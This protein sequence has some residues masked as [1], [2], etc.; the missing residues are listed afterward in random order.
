M[1]SD[2]RLHCEPHCWTIRIFTSIHPAVLPDVF[3]HIPVVQASRSCVPPPPKSA[4]TKDFWP[5]VLE[6][7]IVKPFVWQVA[8]ISENMFQHCWDEHWWTSTRFHRIFV[9]IHEFWG[10]PTCRKP[11]IL[12]MAQPWPFQRPPTMSVHTETATSNTRGSAPG[13]A[14]LCAP[15]CFMHTIEEIQWFIGSL[16]AIWIW[17]VQGLDEFTSF[18]TAM[19]ILGRLG[20]WKEEPLVWVWVT[21]GIPK[22]GCLEHKNDQVCGLLSL[23]F[24]LISI[25][26]LVHIV[27]SNHLS[28]ATFTAACGFYCNWTA[29][30][31]GDTICQGIA[32]WTLNFLRLWIFAIHRLIDSSPPTPSQWSKYVSLGLIYSEM[33]WCTWI[34]SSSSPHTVDGR[35]PASPWMVETL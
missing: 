20:S 6:W 4:I 31:P 11:P 5:G 35:N 15:I 3:T 32:I 17:I 1:M 18:E 10:T 19:W 21:V 34:Y 2:V 30:V 25:Y 12:G 33:V 22:N 27:C 16:W 28:F 13:T 7:N 24:W 23:K 29:W 9:I 26:M 14:D 8:F